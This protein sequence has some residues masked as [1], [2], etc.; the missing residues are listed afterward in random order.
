[1]AK[2]DCSECGNESVATTKSKEPIQY[3][4][5]CGSAILLEVDDEEEDENE[6]EE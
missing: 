4:P 6:D 5:L 2:I 3:C 1:M